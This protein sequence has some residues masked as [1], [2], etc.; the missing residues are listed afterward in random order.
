MT[1]RRLATILTSIAS[2]LVV[3]AGV[4][5]AFD[6]TA[7]SPPAAPAPTATVSP[8]PTPAPSVVAVDGADVD[9]RPDDELRLSP[10]AQDVLEQATETPERFDL[11]GGLRGSDKTPAGVHTGPLAAQEWPGCKTAFHKSFSHRTA[12][13]KA[14]GLHYTGGLN[15]PGFA[16][17]DGLTAYSANRQYEVSWH[18]GIDR[19]G[20]CVYNVPIKYKAWTI[21]NLNS[22]TINFEIVGNGREPDYAGT[23]GMRKLAQIVQRIHRLYPGIPIKLGAVSSCK[24]T[25]PGII[26]HWMGGACSGGHV[27]IKPY[28]LAAVIRK[29]Q[30]PKPLGTRRQRR[31]C[32]LIVQ[33][34][35]DMRSGKPV[36]GN[37]AR[38]N[39]E[40]RRTLDAAG[41]RCTRKG[42]QRR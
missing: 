25:R 26:T 21:G 40:R 13:I 20:N 11:G 36:S 6:T 12:A 5:G 8:A 37:R 42:L 38:I 10:P 16:D 2:L 30:A 28:D 39:L 18:F 31:D 15:K 7:P 23:A 41:W 35:R 27:D 33:V 34:R 24:V 14:I 4:L 9:T 32:Q 19:E 1:R 17:L 3:L 29:L 22:E